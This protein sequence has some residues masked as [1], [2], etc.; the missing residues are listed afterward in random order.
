MATLNALN[1]TSGPALPG[2]V[3]LMNA[4]TAV[5][6]GIA[7]IA[8]AGM[9]LLWVVRQPL[10]V[11]RSISVEGDLARNSVSTLRANV[12]A[13]LSGNFFTMDLAEGRRAFES[14]PWVRQAV[15]NRVWPNRLAVRLQEHRAA[16]LWVRDGA[17]DRLVNTYGEVFE[18]NLGDVED[19]SLT[20]LSGPDGTSALMLTMLTRLRPVLAAMPAQIKALNLSGRGSWR[21]DLDTG[22]EVELGRGSDDEVVERTRRFVATVGQVISRYERPLEYADLRHNEGYAVRLRGISTTVETGPA[23]A[24]KRK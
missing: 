18:A 24:P 11:V 23:I 20:P 10:F 2:D 5:L 7:A 19:E 3:R 4:T 14:V 21:V 1:P 17:E 8:L 9:A 13:R 22:A 16:A 12:A 15:V 6:L